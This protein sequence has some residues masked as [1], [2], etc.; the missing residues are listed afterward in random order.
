MEN[1][2]NWMVETP[3]FS[4]DDT[5][6]MTLLA[7]LSQSQSAENMAQEE[8]KNAGTGQGLIWNYKR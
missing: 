1:L 7:D 4:M 5:P 8:M 6:L 2:A 3:T